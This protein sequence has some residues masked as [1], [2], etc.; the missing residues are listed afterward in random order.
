MK[1]KTLVI[2]SSVLCFAISSIVSASTDIEYSCE[3]KLIAYGGKE[4]KINPVSGVEEEVPF[5]WKSE[6][7]FKMTVKDSH[8]FYTKYTLPQNQWVHCKEYNG[9]HGV[10]SVA[11]VPYQISDHWITMSVHATKNW[12]INL[13]AGFVH[14]KGEEQDAFAWADLIS[15]VI[16]VGV[17]ADDKTYLPATLNSVQMIVGCR[18]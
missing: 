2:V 10:V 13:R 3:A 4:K 8:W 18:R 7:Q 16:G 17:T 1:I 15:N 9:G 5:M 6:Q 12:E 11:S 14:K